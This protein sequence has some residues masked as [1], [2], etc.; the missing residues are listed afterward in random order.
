[1][2]TEHRVRERENQ[3]RNETKGH[4]E[5]DEG[6]GR[7]GVGVPVRERKH[8]QQVACPKAHGASSHKALRRAELHQVPVNFF[9]RPF[10]YLFVFKKRNRA[11]GTHCVGR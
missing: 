6:E 5:W 10:I 3:E 1:M 4:A 11:R 8:E 9:V 7:G 2:R